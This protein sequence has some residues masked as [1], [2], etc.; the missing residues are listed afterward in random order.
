MELYASGLDMKHD[1]IKMMD[2]D[3]YIQLEYIKLS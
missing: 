3:L 1:H 2:I